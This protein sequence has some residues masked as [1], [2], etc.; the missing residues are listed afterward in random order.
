MSN[1]AY[2][3]QMTR[4]LAACAQSGMDIQW[5]V[6]QAIHEFRNR[7]GFDDATVGDRGNFHEICHIIPNAVNGAPAME[8]K[9]FIAERIFLRGNY[10]WHNP[11]DNAEHDEN[12][13][14]E[15]DSFDELK[16]GIK[17]RVSDG[18]YLLEKMMLDRKDEILFDFMDETG[19]DPDIM[20][21]YQDMDI[22]PQREG[23]RVANVDHWPHEEFLHDHPEYED[24]LN[25][26]FDRDLELNRMAAHYLNHENIP[27][28]ELRKTYID[29]RESEEVF[30]TLTGGRPLQQ[31]STEELL[32]LPVAFFG[33]TPVQEGD[34]INYRP[35][36]AFKKQEI[37]ENLQMPER[38]NGFD[39]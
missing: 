32:T 7:N 35:I 9:A 13:I 19:F 5:T 3:T 10:D 6:G 33:I 1:E 37:L 14:P 18:L 16:S 20:A 38:H 22:T 24:E 34:E 17:I 25:Q 39:Q 11:H 29:L 31:F 15:I 23:P 8:A 36:P 27:E 28:E 26:R 30:R 2:K 12:G 4:A 21:Q